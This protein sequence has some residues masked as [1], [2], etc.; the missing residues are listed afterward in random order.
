MTSVPGHTKVRGVNNAFYVNVASLSKTTTCLLQN[1]GTPETPAM[2]TVTWLNTVL[3]TTALAPIST[4][5]GTAGSAFLRDC[6]KTLVSS[7]RVFRKVQLLGPS[8]STGGVVG[9]AT[10]ALTD[11]NDF[12]TAYIELPG[13]DGIASGTS[14]PAPVARVG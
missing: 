1:N 4:A 2:S 6:G 3:T 14:T 13:M 7:G 11:S 5:I 8:L 9:A 10:G 12:L